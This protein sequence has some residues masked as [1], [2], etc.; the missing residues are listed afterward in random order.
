MGL[1]LELKLLIITILSS[2]PWVNKVVLISAAILKMMDGTELSKVVKSKIVKCYKPQN[3]VLILF[4]PRFIILCY[5]Y[6]L[7]VYFLC[8]DMLQWEVRITSLLTKKSTSVFPSQDWMATK[9]RKT[10]MRCTSHKSKL[11]WTN[12]SLIKDLRSSMH[13]GFLNLTLKLRCWDVTSSCMHLGNR[14]ERKQ[15]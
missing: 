12:M 2:K 14:N 1:A 8:T 10:I 9:G 15:N 13:L 11:K 5:V 7:F 6:V 4:M 3:G